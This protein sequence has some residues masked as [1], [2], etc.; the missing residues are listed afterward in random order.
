MKQ[1]FLFA[2][3][4]FAALNG[5]SQKVTNELKFPKGAKIEV[6]TSIN[7]VAEVMGEITTTVTATRTLDVEDVKDG[8]ATIESKVKRLQFTFEGMGQSQ[9]FDSE[10]EADMK[11]EGGKMAEKGLKNKYSMKV[12]AQG[13]ILEV[14]PDDDNP[15]GKPEKETPA[16]PMSGMMDG[17]LGGMDLPK[18]GDKIDF[19]ILPNKEIVKGLSW[20]DTTSTAPELKRS[21]TFTVSD[22]TED[23]IVVSFTEESSG[24]ITRENMGME[25]IIDQVEKTT[26]EILINK[27][28]GLPSQKKSTKTTEGTMEVMGQ[29][30][31]LASKTVVTETI[32]VK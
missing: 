4:V 9:T 21:A 22:I 19:A 27:R 23:N 25:I 29:T 5:Q 10:N 2:A 31:P 17:V 8:V 1:L 15:N 6:V 12:D 28:T 7:N 18:A 16:D 26:G 14:T 11:G 20:N 30:M 32:S 3:V 13:K 24:R